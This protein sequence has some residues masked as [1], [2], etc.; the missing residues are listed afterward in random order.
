[1][2][3]FLPILQQ[4]LI[5]LDAIS[6]GRDSK[7][8]AWQ[9]R[10]SDESSLS[11]ILPIEDAQSKRPDPWLLHSLTVNTLNFC[12]F[13]SCP[14]HPSPDSQNDS[15]FVAVPGVRDSDVAVWSLPSQERAYTVGMPQGT[16]TG[17]L[18]FEQALP[19]M[20]ANPHG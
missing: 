2:H 11:S 1:M 13:A 8:L 10:E 5:L 17:R 7:L 15:I 6:H 16:K 4:R 9:L 20:R 14:V 19:A 3:D 18:H 12:S